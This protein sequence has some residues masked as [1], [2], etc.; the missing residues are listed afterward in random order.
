M[1]PESDGVARSDFLVVPVVSKGTKED[2]RQGRAEIQELRVG[3]K[4][5]DFNPKRIDPS[6]KE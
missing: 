5:L 4:I 3:L 1:E 2:L 6:K